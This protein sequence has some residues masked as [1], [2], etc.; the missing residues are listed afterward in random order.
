[1]LRRQNPARG[2][3][4]RSAGRA[5]QQVRSRSKSNHCQSTR[6]C[7]IADATRPRR[8]GNRMMKRREFI[9]LLGGVATAWPFAGGPQQSTMPVIGFLRPTPAA[10]FEYILTAFRQGLND[11]GFVEGKNVTI[12]YRW[13]DNQPDRLPLLAADLVSRQVAV[14]VGAGSGTPHAA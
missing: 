4:R 9:T 13:A 2:K 14:I 12:E 6:P 11:A 7:H 3:A 8:R 5:T 10:G 1:R